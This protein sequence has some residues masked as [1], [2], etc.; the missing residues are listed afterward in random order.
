MSPALFDYCKRSDDIGS[1]TVAPAYRDIFFGIFQD[2]MGAGAIGRI[3]FCADRGAQRGT[4]Q[5]TDRSRGHLALADLIADDA[6]RH[7]TEHGPD[8]IAI[9]LAVEHA[10]AAI[11]Q[12]APA[13]VTT[14]M[15]AVVAI[16]GAMGIIII[17]VISITIMMVMTMMMLVFASFAM[18][19]RPLRRIGANGSERARA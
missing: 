17:V 9:A 1:R 6:A 2:L 15:L 13:A 18:G 5:T 10:E 19:R 7:A 16:A 4:E 8:R 14:V 12:F 3:H 11:G